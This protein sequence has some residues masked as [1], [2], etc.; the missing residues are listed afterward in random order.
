MN[1]LY[2]IRSRVVALAVALFVLAAL[3]LLP[4]KAQAAP[5]GN[6][7]KVES[8]AGFQGYMKQNEWFP[9]RLSLTNMTD[10]D[11][12]G[13][14]VI[15]VVSGNNG[16]VTDYLVSVELPIGTAVKT[17]VGVPGDVLNKDNNKITF[18]KNSF[19]DKE[20]IP[21]IGNDYID[22]KQT[23]SYTIGVISRDPD[24]L[25]FMPTLNQR[26]YD[27]NVIPITE[28]ELPED[29]LLLDMLDTL[30]IN[31]TATS[32]WSERKV[33]AINEWVHLG[34]SLVLSGGAGYSK[35]AEAFQSLVPVQAG[36][37]SEISSA[38]ALSNFSGS[39]MDLKLTKPITIST[40]NLID[41]QIELAEDGVPLAVTR[42][43]GFGKVVFAAFDPSLEPL[44]TWSGSAMLWAKL[45]QQHANPINGGMM[46]RSGNM[47]WNM[48]NI[49]DQF[50]SI[51]PPHF[52]LLLLMFVG[53]M[54][55]VAPVLYIILAKTDRR[56]WA[57]WVIPS[58]SV[59]TAV[60]IFYF[61][62]EDKRTLSAHTVE[63]IELTGQ[64]DGVRS[65]A[66][67]IFVPTGGKISMNFDE[68]RGL[69]TYSSDLQQGG[70]TLSGKTQVVSEEDST[71]VVWRS[72]PYWSTRKTWLEKRLIEGGAGQFAVV[73]KQVQGSGSVQLTIKNETKSDLTNV[74]V[75]ID[76]QSKSM[77]DLKVGESGQVV[78]ASTQAQ[79]FGY[80][81]YGQGVFPYSS[82][83]SND[84]YSRQRELVDNYMNMNNN[85]IV[86]P[87]PLIV[88]FSI[89]HEAG[90]TVN[91]NDVKTD[92]LIMWTQKLSESY[93]DGNRAIISVGSLKPIIIENKLQRMDNYGNGVIS[94]GAGELI[95]EYEIPNTQDV[96][97]DKLDIR[98]DNG[99]NNQNLAWSVWNDASGEWMDTASVDVDHDPSSLLIQHHT[100]RMKVTVTA[101]ADVTLPQIGLE[102]EVKK[103]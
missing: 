73:Y 86:A 69:I 57:W 59:I 88:G 18:Y 96:A 20:T 82:N 41:G 67:G 4:W 97:Y 98:L 65:G 25:N 102:G 83:R 84:V 47:Y 72:V 101:D 12:K 93:I 100:L 5:Q 87:S 16:S 3:M 35:T 92:H 17:T 10:K 95:F 66:T 22:I 8:K 46:Y 14:L 38:S 91:G 71:T 15:S 11:L 58:L 81:S 56:E 21:L 13:D 9:I 48:Q 1:R 39:D 24:T 79:P 51:K 99:F 76:G 33:K 53:Y 49:I 78:I 2:P 45:L 54:V 75:L 80:N 55:V 29:P 30:V 103:K 40:G 19:N 68:K 6:G 42:K 26:G 44:S 63:V 62:A 32:G 64:G 43:I 77:G 61:G 28:E 27:I 89:D 94:M 70:L 23:G 74:S 90:Y 31:D 34:G 52:S 37:V 36:G 85:G 60:S 50:P 7:I